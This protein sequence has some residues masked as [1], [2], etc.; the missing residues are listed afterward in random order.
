MKIA[1]IGL[2]VELCSWQG[3]TLTPLN[4]SRK[5]KVIADLKKNEWRLTL[6]IP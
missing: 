4:E 1:R 3:V 2:A 6:R 5:Q